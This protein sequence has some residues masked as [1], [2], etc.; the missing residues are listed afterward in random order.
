MH[1]KKIIFDDNELE[2]AILTYNRV[3]FI[4][5]W[6]DK[7]YID[8]V[9]RNILISIYDSSTNTETEEY[10]SAFNLNINNKINY[11]KLSPDTILGYKPMIPLLNSESKYVWV[12][13]DSRRHD[14]SELDIQV[15]PALKDDYDYIL[16]L[17]KQDQMCNDYSTENLN[18]FIKDCFLSSTCIGYSIYKTELFDY[19]KNNPA[20]MKRLDDLFSNNYGFGWLGYFYSAFA[21][22]YNNAKTCKV[23]TINILPS[24]KK[25]VWA[26][27]FF[28]CWID[29][30]CDVIDNIPQTYSEKECVPKMV[31]S[32]LR[33]CSD[34]Y[35]YIGRKVGD[36]NIQNFNRYSSSGL[37]DRVTV[38]TKLFRLYAEA[39]MI[40]IEIRHRLCKCFSFA[41]RCLCFIKRK[42][43]GGHLK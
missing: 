30:M 29:D 28:Q 43:S 4:K 34:K 39:P 25:Q 41:E 21:Q 35:L 26:K 18:K 40:Y 17:A 8:A 20:E 5:E 12:C 6:L 31:W 27:L 37:L 38:N 13:G 11:V 3:D 33:L 42:I 9:E 14:F 22:K 16:F 32:D 1:C 19:L 36:L 10:I 24:K 15:F 2:I 23:K 7:T